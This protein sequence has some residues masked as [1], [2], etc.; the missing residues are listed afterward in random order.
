MN[1][2][3]KAVVD[4]KQRYAEFEVG[5]F[6]WFVITKESFSVVDYNKLSTA[7]KIGLVEII[8]KIKPNTYRLKLSNN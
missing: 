2:K 5:D 8:R 6:V 1:T 4:Q 3:I 7:Q